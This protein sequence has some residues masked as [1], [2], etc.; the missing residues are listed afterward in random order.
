MPAARAL[1]AFLLL[2]G[3]GRALDNGLA[4]VCTTGAEL[5]HPD[6]ALHSQP[7]ETDS[8][9]LYGVCHLSPT[10]ADFRFCT[11]SCDCGPN[12]DCDDESGA[13]WSFVCQRFSR[14]QMNEPLRAFC[15]QVCTS[16]SDCPPGYDGCEVVTGD[17]S[18]C[19]QWEGI[20][21]PK[22]LD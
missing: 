4:T 13:G 3:C 1:L 12:R 19:V 20:L 6:G 10:I 14:T 16:V 9:C 17:R 5:L 7:C 11:K 2:S 21:E 22:T 18:V 15:T 8:D